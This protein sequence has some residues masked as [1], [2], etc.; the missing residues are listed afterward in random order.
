M[1]AVI[2]II[3]LGLPHDWRFP[4][5]VDNIFG[6]AG[7]VVEESYTYTTRYSVA[8]EDEDGRAVREQLKRSIRARLV[9]QDAELFIKLMDDN[10]WDVSFLVDTF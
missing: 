6:E 2:P 9:A 8:A 10:N 7:L 1:K 4:L 5:E 3:K